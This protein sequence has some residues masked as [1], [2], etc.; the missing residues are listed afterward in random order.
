MREKEDRKKIATEVEENRRQKSEN[1]QVMENKEN[2]RGID[3]CVALVSSVL[4][5][6]MD[7]INIIRVKDLRV[8]LRY[9]FGS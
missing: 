2:L 4:I 1:K 3:S 7:H 9:N 6:G 5:F 8:I